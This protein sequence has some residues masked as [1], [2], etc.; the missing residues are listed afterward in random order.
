ME[1]TCSL[2]NQSASMVLVDKLTYTICG[3]CGTIHI[4]ETDQYLRMN[5]TTA[6]KIEAAGKREL[7]IVAEA[8]EAIYRNWE[9][10]QHALVRG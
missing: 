1:M 9:D 5:L 3:H 4:A 8:M 7:F 2:C 10:I 6:N